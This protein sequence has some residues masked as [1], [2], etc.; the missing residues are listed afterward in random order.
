[1]MNKTLR[2]EKNKAE[3][4][5]LPISEPR[6]NFVMVKQHYAPNCIEHR[7]YRTGFYE[8]HES[9]TG[10]G[11]EGCGEVY[12]IGPK[13]TQFEPGDR[14]LVFQGWPC[15]YCHVCESG[16]S[17]T[18]CVN[19]KFP[20]HIEEFNKS[21]S[22]GN[23][24]CEYRLVPESMLYPLP[25]DLDFKYAAAGNCL[26]GCTFSAM[27]EHHIG[28]EHVCLIG[29]VGFIGHATL[30]NLKHRGA[31]V[32]ALGR[33]EKRMQIARELGADLIVNPEDSD[34]MDQV[35]DHTPNGRGVDFAFECSGFPYYQ[36][37]CLDTLKFYGTMIQLGYA[38]DL[39]PDLKWALNTEYGLC[40]GHKT[41]TAHFDVNFNH[42][43]SLVETLKN[44]WIQSMV[45]RL[46][47]HDLPM[48]QAAEAFELLNQ[49]EAGKVFFR[50]FE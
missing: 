42:R 29:G 49:K 17:P 3:V 25:D 22:G 45:D 13:V 44:P 24:F 14:V 31:K 6:E 33:H 27:I 30:V 15:G 46:V 50:P 18:H 1:M 34:W 12:S 2:I 10:C 40:W 16:L 37:K 39:G 23:G 41:I 4:I 47:T 9:P 35:R 20:S 26:I 28:P 5:E 48:S 19:L 21:K 36:Q 7:V 43:T 32:I 8:F 38:S 11:H